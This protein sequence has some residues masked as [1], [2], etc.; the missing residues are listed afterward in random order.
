MFEK[1]FHFLNQ[2]KE[3]NNREWYH[4]NKKLFQ[5]AK[6]E[7]ESFTEILLHEVSQF[8]N[9]IAGLQPK[10]CIF[11]IFRDVRFSVDKSPYKTNF[12]AFLTPGGR[13][14]M[15]AGYYLHIEPG[16]SLIASGIYQPP[17]PVLNAIRGDIYTFTEEFKNII[18]EDHLRK[19]FGDITG[20]KLK[21][22]PRGFPKDFDD[23]ELLKFKNYGLIRMENDREMMKTDILQKIITCFKVSSPFVKFLNEAIKNT[24]T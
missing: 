3:N 24:I 16:A 11:R 9:S 21:S 18:Q 6:Q 13:K 15:N 8:D 23:I 2:L 5:D 22:P 4:N 19:L 1:S 12:G 7:F 10:D 17:T 20:E 14:A